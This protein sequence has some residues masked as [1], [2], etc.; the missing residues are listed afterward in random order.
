MTN[1]SMTLPG[2]PLSKKVQAA[3]AESFPVAEQHMRSSAI[4][5][6]WP[7]D[8]ANDISITDNQISIGSSG[9]DWEFGMPGKPPTPVV[10]ASTNIDQATVVIFDDLTERLK[11]AGVL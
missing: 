10:R 1:V 4:Q 6:G 3:L 7:E 9:A 2:T 11:K 8:A 5:A